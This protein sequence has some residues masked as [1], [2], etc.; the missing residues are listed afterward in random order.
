MRLS[1]FAPVNPK[2]LAVNTRFLSNKALPAVVRE[3]KKQL[4]EVAQ[5]EMAAQNPGW[6]QS[7][8]DHYIV[9]IAFHM[10]DKRNDV[11]GPL[12]RAIDAIFEGAGLFDSRVQEIYLKRYHVDEDQVG[13]DV[14]ISQCM[15]W[16][17]DFR[18]YKKP[19]KRPVAEWEE[20]E[21][22]ERNFD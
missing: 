22:A 5:L 19:R 11:D 3:A 2:D 12:K 1:F 9:S 17:Y 6:R 10:P 14:E 13:I 15:A 4:A 21:N 16:D 20:E 7:G 8:T 18:E